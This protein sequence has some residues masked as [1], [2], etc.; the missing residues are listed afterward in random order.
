MIVVQ[1]GSDEFFVAGSGI[2]AAIESDPD[3]SSGLAGIISIEEGTL[4]NGQWK[5]VRHLNGD[6]SNQGRDVS[7]PAHGFTLLRVKLYRTNR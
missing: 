7:L 6:Q 4:E 1:S 2:T 3:T 5:T